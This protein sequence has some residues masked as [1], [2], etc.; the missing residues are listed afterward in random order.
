MIRAD[1]AKWLARGHEYERAGRPIDAMVCYRRAINSNQHSVEAQYRLGQLL[2]GLGRHKEAHAAWLA[3]LA[4]SPEDERL[5][6]VV[7]GTARRA[8]A[9]SE[10][11]DAYQRILAGKPEHVGAR[12]GLALSRVAQGDE[13]AYA[14]LRTVLGNGAAY[15]RWDDLAFTLAAAAPSNARSAFLLGVAASRVSEFP[16]LLLA[17]AAE[18][19]IASGAYDQAAEVLARAELFAQTIYDPETLRRLALAEASSGVSKSWAERYAQRCVEQ[20]ASAPPM[21]WPRRTAG[22]PLRIAYLIMPG[23]PIVI[24]GVSIEPGAYLR[25]VVAAHPRERF[26]ASV[27]AV[28]D[29]GM[30][31]LAELLP[32]T[33]PLEKLDAT[34]ELAAARRVAESDLDALIDLTGMRAPLG[35]LLARRAARTLWTYPGLAGAHVAPLPIH[36]L[37]ALADSDEAVLTEHRL[38]LERALGEACAGELA[39]S[40]ASTHTAADLAV[41]WRFAVAAHEAG[42]LDAA[43]A[44]YRDVLAEQPDYAPA[45]HLLGVLL[46]DRGQRHDAERAFEAAVAAAPAYPEPRI[47]LASLYSEE[48]SARAAGKLCVEGIALTPNEVSL[49]RALGQARFAQGRGRA[50][51]KAFKNALMLAPADGETHYNQGVALQMMHRRG[52]A[53]RAYQRALALSPELIAA[54]FNIG[55][56]FRE[57]G[58]AQAAVSAFEHVLAR[59]PRHVAAHKALAE[60]LLAERRIDAYLK[61]FDRFEVACPDALPLA[62]VAL[63][64]CQYRGDFA[65]LDRYL[66]R[67]QRDEF[68]AASD[69]ELAN[70][71]EELLYLLL[72]FDFDPEAHLLLY[73]RYDAVAARV[74]GRPSPLP[75]KRRP[76][77][78]RIG[79]LSG[80]LRNHVMGRMMWP[81]IERHD[82]ERF[83]LFFYSL[84]AESDDW[85]A[86]YRGLSEH[87]AVIADLSES[88][89]ARR[90]AAD[91]IDLLV[92]LG[93]HTAGAKPGILALKPARVQLTH[94]ASAGVVGL[95]VIDFKLTDACADLPE[96]QQFQLETLLPMDGCVYPYRHVAPAPEHPFHRDRLGIAADRIVIGA[97]VSALKL[98]RRCLALWHEILER[99]PEAVIAVSPLSPEMRAVFGRLFSA[100]GIAHSRVCVVPQGRGEAENRAR[101]GMV[102]FVLDPIPFGSANGTLEPLD[103]GVPVVTLAGRRHGERCAYT[104]LA[105]LGVTQ[106]VARSEREYVE[107][108]LRLA[109]DVAFR[110][111]VRGAI[112]SALERS[113]LTDMDA[114]TRHL[115]QAYLRALEQRYPAASRADVSHG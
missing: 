53:L 33:V 54:D 6:L 60:T 82:R 84:S 30:E 88:E 47:A 7:A 41:A 96:N 105:N 26:A 31:S 99:V 57:Q 44:G 11:I 17:L 100:A 15:R 91:E 29:A 27:Y 89:A 45:Q 2:R 106:T 32:S 16:P 62:V 71:L 97:F 23:A 93:T 76:G 70:C 90:I 68:K 102:D 51:L 49:W 109:S 10:A 114:H 36:A 94:V 3:G 55:V 95:S 67:L 39:L 87:F 111:E 14:D 85:T 18:E 83:E 1:Y 77:R 80:D 74:Y 42:E 25:A 78:I 22:E 66:D 63:Q 9:H 50:A 13:A 12:V 115:E 34:A 107:I 59:E 103:M 113:A 48:G 46:R 104:I 52:L 24:G 19:M 28:G 64:A 8:G 92:D 37:P 98:S 75:E 56:I 35:L 69:T 61:A 108:A 73:K 38:T 4:L 79:Y 112:R 110:T 58:R 72:F 81:A 40:T 5:L 43:I 65:S 86:R 20:V 101:Y 21:A